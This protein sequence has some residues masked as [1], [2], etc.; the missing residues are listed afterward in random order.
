MNHVAAVTVVW[1]ALT[2]RAEVL[3]VAAA[4]RLGKKAVVGWRDVCNALCSGWL[5]VLETS[6][7]G[8]PF[9]LSLL[10]FFC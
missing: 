10:V 6:L 8:S 3:I 9:F 2:A 4:P 7:R 1:K 5:P